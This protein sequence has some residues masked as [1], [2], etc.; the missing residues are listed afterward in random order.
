MQI[1][2]ILKDI[3]EQKFAPLY[4]LMG[5]EPYFIDLI[6]NE[7]EKNVLTEEEK[8][9]NQTIV[10][11]KDVAIEDAMSAAKQFPMMSE[12]TLVMVKEA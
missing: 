6:T 9:F 2:A 8:N 5:D 12:R 3:K 7:L 1:E 4:F 10:Y 11:G